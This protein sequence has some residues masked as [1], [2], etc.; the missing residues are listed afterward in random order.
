[1][2][3]QIVTDPYTGVNTTRQV[4]NSTVEVTITN[5][6]FSPYYYSY[7]YQGTT[8]TKNTS[9]WYDVQFKGHFAQDWT[10]ANLDDLATQSISSTYTVIS[11]P[12]TTIIDPVAYPNGGA[13]DF[14][15]IAIT[16]GWFPVVLYSDVNL[17]MN[18]ISKNSSWS[19]MQTINLT[20]G[21]VAVSTSSNP[22]ATLCPTPTVPELSWLAIVPLLFSIFSAVVIR[23]RKTA[24]LVVS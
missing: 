9:L 20:Y 10:D 7:E 21:S 18:F 15:V 8:I 2:Y 4:N 17:P 12:Q 13:V 14:R 5:Q 1:V 16:G 11:L 24:N 19:N 6:P 3:N 23:H 22:L